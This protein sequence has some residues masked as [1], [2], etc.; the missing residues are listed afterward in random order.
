MAIKG[1]FK[2]EPP[3]KITGPFSFTVTVTNNGAVG[4]DFSFEA[5]LIDPATGE[6]VTRIWS[7]NVYLGSGKSK[8]LNFQLAKTRELKV[9]D[10]T[11]DLQVLYGGYPI[12]TNWKSAV[13]TTVEVALQDSGNGGNRTNGGNGGKGRNG[14]NGGGSNEGS[15]TTT[16]AAIVGAVG[17]GY[18]LSRQ[19]DN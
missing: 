4:D 18:V 1:Q 6:Q 14:N 11:Y 13:N 12:P 10:G 7:T 19:G 9:D 5:V 17:L 2:T 8:D 15:S 3:S 16:I